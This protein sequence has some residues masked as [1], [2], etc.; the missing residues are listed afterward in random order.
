[1][2]AEWKLATRTNVCI[3]SPF[4]RW[5]SMPF[6][7]SDG[8]VEVHIGAPDDSASAFAKPHESMLII[9]RRARHKHARLFCPCEMSPERW[10]TLLWAYA[11]ACAG[12]RGNSRT[13]EVALETPNTPP[14]AGS[15]LP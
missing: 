5:C 15:L 1:M 6:L 4:G 13:N 2:G 12:G 8:G 11:G 14:R 10:V 3:D 7:H 9:T